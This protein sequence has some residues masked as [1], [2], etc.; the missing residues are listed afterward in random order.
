MYTLDLKS[1]PALITDKSTEQKPQQPTDKQKVSA[2][3]QQSIA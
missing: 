3:T 2:Y 1:E